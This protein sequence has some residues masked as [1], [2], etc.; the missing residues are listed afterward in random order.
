MLVF[1]IQTLFSAALYKVKGKKKDTL[2]C[3]GLD[4]QDVSAVQKIINEVRSDTFYRYEFNFC[5][6]ARLV[7]D[8]L[9]WFLISIQNLCLGP[10]T[11]PSRRCLY[12]ILMCIIIEVVFKMATCPFGTFFDIPTANLCWEKEPPKYLLNQ[13]CS[14]CRGSIVNKA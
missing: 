11:C 8:V 14:W 6:R 5:V 13:R 3:E 7:Y 4:V 1:V 10:I 2:E 12:V 9:T